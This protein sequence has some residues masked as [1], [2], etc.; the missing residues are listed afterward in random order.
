M[1]ECLVESRDSG[2][3]GFKFCS[4]LSRAISKQSCDKFAPSS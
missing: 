3:N 1:P 2:G 4:R